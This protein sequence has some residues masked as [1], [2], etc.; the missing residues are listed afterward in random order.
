MKLMNALLLASTMVVAMAPSVSAYPATPA[1]PA[2]AAPT[3]DVA[4]LLFGNP[5][6]TKAPVGTAITYSYA[7]AGEA[8]FGAPFTDTIVETVDKAAEPQRRTV[9]VKM[10]SGANA[11]PAGPFDSVEQNPVLLLVLE[12]NVQELSKLFHGNVRY[13]KDT[14]RKAWRDNAKIESV[15]VDVNG[16]SMPGTRIT[17]MPFAN[18]AEKDKMLGLEGMTYIVELA[19]S[20]PGQIATIDIHAPTNG[21][22]KFSEILRY[23]SEKTP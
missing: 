4:T 5:Q 23:M 18:D 12:E 21:V 9:E 3:Q 2:S 16:K 20:V 7:K 19:D 22:A 6:W 14:I 13:L 15:S 1:A 11:K 10:F 17:I 8:A